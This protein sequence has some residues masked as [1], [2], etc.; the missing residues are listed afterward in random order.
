ML[1]ITW[2]ESVLFI[3]RVKF[4]HERQENGQKAENLSED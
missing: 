1:A 3:L 2:N 4:V